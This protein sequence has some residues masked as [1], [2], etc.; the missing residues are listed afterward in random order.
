MTRL[1]AVLLILLLA[2]G[3]LLIAVVDNKPL[4]SRSETIS[5]IAVAQARWLFSSNDPRRLQ[6]GEAR[7]TAIPAALIDEGIAPHRTP[8]QMEAANVS[9]A[10]VMSAAAPETV[11]LADGAGDTAATPLSDRPAAL[12]DLVTPGAMTEFRLGYHNFYVITRY[13]RSS[14]YAAAVMDLAAALRVSK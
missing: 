12:I 7:R 11:S 6:A 2:A 14:F 13:N 4:V 3:G 10:I 9:F 5:P 1:L 8:G